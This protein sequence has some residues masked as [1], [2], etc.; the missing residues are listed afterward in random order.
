MP[1]ISGEMMQGGLVA[2]AAAAVM[3]GIRWLVVGKAK[4]LDGLPVLIQALQAEIHALRL[5]QVKAAARLDRAEADIANDKAGRRAFGAVETMVSKISSDIGHL[6][7]DLQK[8]SDRQ[9]K[10]AGEIWSAIN[11]IRDSRDAA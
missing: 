5:E 6:S 3:A 8:L 9:E 1:E 7:S 10:G 4:Q 2:L 11:R